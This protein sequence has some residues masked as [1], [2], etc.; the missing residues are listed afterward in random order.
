[1]LCVWERN[2]ITQMPELKALAAKEWQQIGEWDL[3][4]YYVLN[5]VYNEPM[6]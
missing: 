6:Q 2:L 4:A 3:S 1:M 5:L